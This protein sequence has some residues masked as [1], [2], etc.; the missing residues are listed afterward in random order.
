MNSIIIR[1]ANA[2]DAGLIADLSRQTFY[3]TFA[4]VNTKEDMVLFMNKQFTREALIKEVEEGDGI[5]L[6]ALEGE[7]A[8]GYARLREGEQHS[9]FNNESSIEIARLYALQSYIGKGVGKEL[10]QECIRIARDMNRSIIW[11][12]VW[13]KNGLAIRFYNKW[14]FE[15]FAEHDFILGTDVQRDCLMS[16]KIKLNNQNK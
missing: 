12:G 3:D 9:E 2:A 14:G 11:L 8:V 6:L 16:K 1:Y 15:K 7:E 13:E 5:F 10:M 4:A